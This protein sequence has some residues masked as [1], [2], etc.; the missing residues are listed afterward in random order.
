MSFQVPEVLTDNEREMLAQAAYPIDNDF[1]VK[2]SG[3]HGFG[4]FATRAYQSGEVVF[5]FQGRVMK[6]ADYDRLK[7]EIP[8]L[9]ELLSCHLVADYELY[10][11][12]LHYTDYLNHA[13]DPNILYHCGIGFARKAIAA[14]DE[15]T[16]DY[17]FMYN[18]Q[19]EAELENGRILRG[20]PP[21][22]ILRESTR[23]LY[24]LLQASV[25]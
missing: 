5:Y 2:P 15:L 1:V 23:Q 25:S 13:D 3:I 17:R 14:G 18:D 21:Q 4:C 11:L 24:E 10:D 16:V 6:W 19:D 7:A 9:D 12:K 22:E 8:V 20:L